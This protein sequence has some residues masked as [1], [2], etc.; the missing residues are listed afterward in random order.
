[1][2]SIFKIFLVSIF[3]TNF[4]NSYAIGPNSFDKTIKN[5]KLVVVKFWAS[6][7]A[8][9]S[10]LNP[11]FQK[12]KKALKKEA[13]LVEYNV[14]LGGDILRK[15]NIRYVPTMIIFKNGKEVSRTNS[16]LSKEYIIDWVREYK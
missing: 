2:R 7:C 14:D 5:N 1:M 16:I 15:Y 8:P 12:A 9:C 11:E 13:L 4:V 3:A 10:V 6:W